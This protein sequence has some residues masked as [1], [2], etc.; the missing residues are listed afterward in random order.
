MCSSDL[1]SPL[2]SS[3]AN[4]H[5]TAVNMLISYGADVNAVSVPGS[6]LQIAARRG[7]V[8]VVEFLLAKGADPNLPGGDQFK[9]PLHE[10]AH[11]GSIAIVTLLLDHGA[12]VNA[13][14]IY[15]GELPAIHYAALRGNVEVMKLLRERGAAAWPVEPIT[16]A[17]IENADPVLINAMGAGCTPCHTYRPGGVG[18]R[19]PSLWNVVGREIASQEGFDYSPAMKSMTGSWDFEAL[20]RYL[21]DNY[22]SVPGTNSF[23]GTIKDR[24]KRIAAIAYIR[25]MAD[26]PVPLE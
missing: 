26:N 16:I 20:N 4:G 14:A 23:N 21:A 8:E 18:D 25:K 24:T 9:Q 10:A 5:L 1:E 6:P 11:N 22:G 13:R 19:A 15:R 3:S 12:D 17:E 7:H 2:Y